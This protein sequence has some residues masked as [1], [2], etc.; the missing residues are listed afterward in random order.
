MSLLTII[1]AFVFIVWCPE[2][3]YALTDIVCP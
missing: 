2:E 3:T 1:A